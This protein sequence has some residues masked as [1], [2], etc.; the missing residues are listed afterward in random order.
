MSI[1]F[2][3]F[4]SRIGRESEFKPI[5]NQLLSSLKQDA[6]NKYKNY[7]RLL[8]LMEKYWPEYQN[9]SRISHLLKDHHE[10]IFDFY[11][12]TLFPFRKRGLTYED[13]EAPTPVDFKLV[14]H[15]QYNKKEI[16]AVEEVIEEL[17]IEEKLENVLKRIFIFVISSFGPMVEKIFQR[18]FAF[19]FSSIDS[20]KLPNGEYEVVAVISGREQ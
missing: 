4:I 2:K 5:R 6:K 19:Q 9:R 16:E 13:P 20:K 1:N 17:N 11:L 10:E 12:N 8:N 15:Y 7:P 14:Y 18:P 3:R